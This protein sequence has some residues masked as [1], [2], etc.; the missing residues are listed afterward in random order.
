MGVET[1]IPPVGMNA[2][3]PGGAPPRRFNYVQL[4]IPVII[5][6]CYEISYELPDFV[7]LMNASNPNKALKQGTLIKIY[8]SQ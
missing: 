8:R 1:P 4:F 2:A 5:L 6:P 3:A 7:V